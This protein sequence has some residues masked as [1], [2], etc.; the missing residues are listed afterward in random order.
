MRFPIGAM[1][2]GDI[3]DR[4]MKLLFARL[5][6]FYLLNLIVLSPIIG[7]QILIPL[8]VSQGEG[9]G[10]MGPAAFLGILATVIYL[11]LLVPIATAATLHIVLQDYAGRPV[12]TGSAVSFALS[13]FGPLLATTILAG[14]LIM[15]GFIL[16]VIPGIY[17]AIT[18]TFAS[19]VVVSEG[20]SGME[21][22]NRSKTLIEG[23]R[24]R[25]FGVMFL[26]GLGSGLVNV[27][28]TMALASAVPANKIVP[29]ANGLTV[30]FNFLNHVITTVVTQLVGILFSTF[31]A[32]CLTLL[33]L[34]LR[35]RKEGYDLEMAAGIESQPGD[36]AR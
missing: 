7:L 2:V 34:D 1:T 20:K 27:A 17:L 12:S 9:L 23:F 5:P 21:A 35:I 13:K 6:V 30:E 36:D 8:L 19:Q 29:T 24:W 28:I 14:L 22:L 31:Q 33:Y 10:T 26:I 25:V 11:V 18:Y 15:C 32:V 3:L 4:G 16:L